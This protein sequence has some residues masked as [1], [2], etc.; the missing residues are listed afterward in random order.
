M[1][2]FIFFVSL[3]VGGQVRFAFL[4]DV[5]VVPSNP[6]EEALRQ[7]V[8]EINADLFDFVVVTGDLTNMGSDVELVNVKSILDRLK[9]RYYVVPGT[10]ET[11]WSES[12]GLMFDSLWGADRF[13]FDIDQYRFVGYNTGPYMKMGD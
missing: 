1:L 11:N 10:H 9:H 13:V 7:A 2:F 6:Q 3:Q 5:H 4:T 12:A 8:D